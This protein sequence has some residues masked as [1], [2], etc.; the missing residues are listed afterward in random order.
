VLTPTGVTRKLETMTHSG[1]SAPMIRIVDGPRHF[2]TRFAQRRGSAFTG[3][4]CP[5]AN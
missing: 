5:R 2:L 4:S 3:L 1:E